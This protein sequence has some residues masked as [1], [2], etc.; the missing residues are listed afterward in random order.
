ML[1]GR[2]RAAVRLLTEKGGCGVLDPE[3]EAQ[4]KD[5]PLGKTVFKG[6]L[7]KHPP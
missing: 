1:Q 7:K 5:G 2:V 6:L 3:S 4:G